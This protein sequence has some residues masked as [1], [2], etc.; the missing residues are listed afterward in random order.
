MKYQDFFSWHFNL[1][2][3]LDFN[4]KTAKLTLSD[5]PLIL[6]YGRL[7]CNKHLCHFKTGA[8]GFFLYEQ[9]AKNVLLHNYFQRLMIL[10]VIFFRVKQLFLL[11][12]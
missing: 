4:S 7:R 9:F 12:K 2:E 6:H 8:P 5:H 1:I 10:I 11:M 3:I